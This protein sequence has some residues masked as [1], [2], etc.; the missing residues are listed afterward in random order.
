MLDECTLGSFIDEDVL[1]SL[2]SVEVRC[3]EIVVETINGAEVVKSQ[4]VN[5]LVVACAQ[6]HAATC[7]STNIS[8]PTVYSRMKLPVEAK[9]IPTSNKIWCWEHLK[10]I[11]KQLNYDLQMPVGLLIGANCPKA[12]QPLEVIPSV[13]DGPYAVRTNLGWSVV[14]PISSSSDTV[15]CNFVRTNEL[16]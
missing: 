12:L 10:E 1:N 13:N 14:A 16:A 6:T 3:T 15:K 8:L 4:A 9:D 2:S 5:G 7:N 11:R